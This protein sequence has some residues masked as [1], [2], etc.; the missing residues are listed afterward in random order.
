[1]VPLLPAVAWLREAVQMYTMG[2]DAAF[3]GLYLPARLLAL[4]GLVL[5]FYQFVLASR[6]GLL[7]RWFKRASLL[8]THRSLGKVAYLLVLIHGVAMLAF[9]LVAAGEIFLFTEKTLGLIGLVLLTFGV[10]AAWFFK[11][12]KLSLKQW[13][14]IHLVTY[15]VFPMVVVH[16]LALGTTVNSVPLVRALLIAMLVGYALL[17]LHRL[18]LVATRG[19]KA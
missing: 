9:D 14:T 19:R 17:L 6:V 11:P 16:A 5:M 15:V 8:K 1:M 12:L 10:L 13:R 7:Q 3:L 4:V 18:Y 2:L